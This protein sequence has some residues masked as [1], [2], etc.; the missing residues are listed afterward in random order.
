MIET[1]YDNDIL[2]IIKG[3]VIEYIYH[4]LFQYFLYTNLVIFKPNCRK[5]IYVSL[6]A[7]Y[8]FYIACKS[9]LYN[10]KLHIK[11]YV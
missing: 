4:I 9:E 8:A 7:W 11:M 3:F 2:L 10:L 5:Y 6:H 1:I